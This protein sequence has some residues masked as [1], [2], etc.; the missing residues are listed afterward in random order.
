MLLA[1]EGGAHFVE[2]YRQLPG[3][4]ALLVAVSGMVDLE[5][6]AVRLGVDRFL[7]K[8]FELEDVLAIV[9]AAFL[10][11]EITPSTLATQGRTC[12]QEIEYSS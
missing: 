11:V 12:A 3:A 6:E 8:P 1:G 4:S 2:R 7:G 9:S 10:K 5:G